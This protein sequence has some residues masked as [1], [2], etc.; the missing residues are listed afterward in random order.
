MRQVGTGEGRRG[1]PARLEKHP[2]R[3]RLAQTRDPQLCLCEQ[4]G[5]PGVDPDTSSRVRTPHRELSSRTGENPCPHR[6]PIHS[7]HLP[8]VPHQLWTNTA[9]WTDSTPSSSRQTSKKARAQTRT[10]GGDPEGSPSR[11]GMGSKAEGR[12]APS[13]CPTGSWE[14]APSGR[15][16]DNGPQN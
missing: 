5:R 15:P 8:E 4:C 3:P 11:G 16:H 2:P 7:T 9:A 10:R 13:R 6:G 14:E 12:E 1:S